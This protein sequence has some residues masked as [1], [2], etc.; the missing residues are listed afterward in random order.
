MNNLLK[1]G[2]IDQESKLTNAGFILLSTIA[3]KHAPI[4]EKE[5][6]TPQWEYVKCYD[7]APEEE[8]RWEE[9]HK[10]ICIHGGNEGVM[11]LKP[12]RFYTTKNGQKIWEDFEDLVISM[13][14]ENSNSEAYINLTDKKDIIKL[15]DYLTKFIEKDEFWSVQS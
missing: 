11:E 13:V 3:S 5:D 14:D 4:I 8:E 7:I 1:L 10:G 15:R 2:L 9:E 6:E 12:I